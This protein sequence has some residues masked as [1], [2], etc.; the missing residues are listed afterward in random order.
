MWLIQLKLMKMIVGK[1]SGVISCNWHTL[2]WIWRSVLVK[3][4]CAM[5]H[6]LSI[7]FKS[8]TTRR[9]EIMKSMPNGLF[10]GATSRLEKPLRTAAL[11]PLTGNRLLMFA[12]VW[13]FSFKS[14]FL[15]F[16]LSLFLSLSLSFSLFFYFYGFIA[17]V[18]ILRTCSTYNDDL[19]IFT[20]Q[21]IELN[22]SIW[23]LKMYRFHFI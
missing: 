11:A 5:Y 4:H 9:R 8:K 21:F 23:I 1:W 19:L 12:I 13:R 7:A 2:D 10:H 14:H 3:Q 22:S 15:S 17:V 16:F 6:R 20:I 18:S